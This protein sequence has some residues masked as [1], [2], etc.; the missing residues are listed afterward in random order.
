MLIEGNRPVAHK[1]KYFNNM[2]INVTSLPQYFLP[3]FCT[4]FVWS[5]L[6][7]YTFLKLRGQ[8]ELGA[9]ARSKYAMQ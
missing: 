1:L 9:C 6:R 2:Q 5:S 4:R 3:P 8:L 7:K